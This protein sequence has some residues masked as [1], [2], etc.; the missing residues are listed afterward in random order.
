MSVCGL[1]DL[2]V[3][4][5]TGGLA[6]WWSR[7]QLRRGVWGW[8]FRAIPLL[9]CLCGLMKSPWTWCAM[10]CGFAGAVAVSVVWGRT[11]LRGLAWWKVVG[12]TLGASLA[13]LFVLVLMLVA[14]TATDI[15][16]WVAWPDFYCGKLEWRA[17]EIDEKLPFAV[18]HRPIHPFLAEYRRRIRFRSGKRVDIAVDTGGFSPFAVYRLSDGT[19]YLVDGLYR[20]DV[21]GEY[22]IDAERERLW[23]T[24]PNLWQL[25][26][27]G[28]QTNGT[29][30]NS[31]PWTLLK[32][33][34]Y[35]GRLTAH[36]QLVED[37][38][39]PLA[40]PGHE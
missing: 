20:S 5:L 26:E 27:G 29:P 11:P 1:I 24:Q 28:S 34:R 23:A 22:L 38:E 19:Y 39:D 31:S 25:V 2:A 9:L 33:R 4:A 8:A 35:L 17:R 10:A 6:W 7:R 21:H 12:R 36:G 16:Q 3:P 18:E 37:G 32:T 13:C 40:R 15:A 30:R 14:C